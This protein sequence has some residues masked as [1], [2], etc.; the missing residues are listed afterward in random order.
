MRCHNHWIKEKHC[1][2]WTVT[3]HPSIHPLFYLPSQWCTTVQKS[4]KIPKAST[5][6][7]KSTVPSKPPTPSPRPD[8]PSLDCR[9]KF[10]F[11]FLQISGFHQAVAPGELMGHGYHGLILMPSVFQKNWIPVSRHV[12]QYVAWVIWM[13]VS[14]RMLTSGNCETANSGSAQCSETSAFACFF[15]KNTCCRWWF[16][17][18]AIFNKDNEDPYVD[19]DKTRFSKTRGTRPKKGLFIRTIH[20]RVQ[21][22]KNPQQQAGKLPLLPTQRDVFNDSIFND[23]SIY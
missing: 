5:T 16:V 2:K 14:W 8:Q 3:S 7:S 10:P 15:I 17:I 9:H 21:E 1:T 23:W 20:S 4:A 13:V 6:N 18:A 11:A 19:F 22:R 12:E